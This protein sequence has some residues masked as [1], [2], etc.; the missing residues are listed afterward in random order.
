MVKILIYYT[1]LQLSTLYTNI[2]CCLRF[3]V[4]HV[5]VLRVVRFVLKA[6]ALKQKSRS[7]Q[8]QDTQPVVSFL[9]SSLQRIIG[10]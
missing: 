9:S 1:S 4:D 7:K 5:T 3:I 10:I 6:T 8:F 2:W